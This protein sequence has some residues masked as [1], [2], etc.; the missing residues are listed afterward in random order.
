MSVN[1][2]PPKTATF[3]LEGNETRRVRSTDTRSTVLDRLAREGLVTA[4]EMKNKNF[5]VATYYEIENSA[6]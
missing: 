4:S 6:R 5:W 3:L 1:A 2:K